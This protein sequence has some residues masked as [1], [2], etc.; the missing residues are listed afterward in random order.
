MVETFDE[1]GIRFRYPENWELEREETDT[2]WTVSLDSPEKTAFV[3]IRLYEDT[4]DVE[5]VAETALAAMREVYPDLEAEDCVDSL[6][7]RPAIGHDIR[8]FSLD[9]TNTCRIRSFY[10]SRGTVVVM[11]QANDL[12]LEKNEPILRAICA[13]LE[14]D[15]E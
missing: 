8:F 10:C 3:M 2:G 15:D 5:D 12:D 9:L 4:P 13:S 6:A 7:G 1:T 11:C 14:V